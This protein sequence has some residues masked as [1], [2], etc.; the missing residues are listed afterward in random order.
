M[1]GSTFASTSPGRKPSRSPAATAGRVRMIR[2]TSRSD[3]AET[4]NAIARY[5]LPVP[6]GPIANV[7]VFGEMR[8]PR[9]RQTTSS[10]TSRRSSAWSSAASTASTVLGSI[11]WPPSTSSPSSSITARA[12]ATSGSEPS[13]VSRLPRSRIVQRSRSRSA[14]S[15]PSP[16]VASSAATS[17]DT[18]RTSCTEAQCRRSAR[19]HS[20]WRAGARTRSGQ[21]LAH[22]LADGGAVG[23][24]GDLRHDV[25]HHAAEVAHAGRTDLGDRVVDDLLE[26][27]LR[28]RLRH[29][30][31]EH[32]EL[33]LFRLGLLVT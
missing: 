18:D 10:K 3:S 5:V 19:Q 22:E 9:W 32:R 8:L 27:V 1:Y 25:R 29:E 7:T 26:L 33:P 23:A 11:S 30:L 14:S 16:T 31:L 4:A 17:L 24:P 2:P 6:A 15:T 28:E 21:L 20:C 12:W 13:I